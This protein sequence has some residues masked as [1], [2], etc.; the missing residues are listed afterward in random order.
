MLV[1][2]SSEVPAQHIKHVH[3]VFRT[4]E[5]LVLQSVDNSA[6]DFEKLLLDA[7]FCRD[8]TTF[9]AFQIV[10]HLDSVISQSALKPLNHIKEPR[11]VIAQIH[12]KV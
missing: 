9:Q 7:F 2:F 11:S 1:I 3:I 10:S 6:D 12:S 4:C 8:S 5:L